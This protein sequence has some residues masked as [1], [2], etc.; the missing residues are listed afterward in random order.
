MR[1]PRVPEELKRRAFTVDEARQAGL[2]RRQLQGAS[3][4]RL[5]PRTY[6]WRGAAVGR[7]SLYDAALRRSP[8][9]AVLSGWA[10][11]DLHGLDVDPECT[12]EITLPPGSSVASRAGLRVWRGALEP[13]DVVIAHGRRATSVP[14]TLRDLAVRLTLTE[15]VVLVDEALRRRLTTVAE[16]EEW[17]HTRAGRIGVPRLRRSLAHAEPLAESP[18]ESRLRM[19]LVLRGLPRPQAQVSLT[20]V[21]GR[22]VGRPDLYY[23][24]ARLGI[25][26]D[27][28]THRD[29]LAEDNR[30]QNLLLAAGIRLLRFT[31]A[32]IYSAPDRVASQVRAL[33]RAA[34]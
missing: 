26:Y 18:M 32:D 2:T 21:R 29:S 24:E 14:R 27:G 33:L 13:A 6:A 1:R 23:P 9:D 20:D 15:S 31:A 11:A 3:W 8:A 12:P 30:R 28:T 5:A 16:L 7:R 25:E 22:F 10:A 17:V 19:L 4:I 34:A